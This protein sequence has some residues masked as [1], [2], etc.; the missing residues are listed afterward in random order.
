MA[1][2]RGENT[3][4]KM[5]GLPHCR[6]SVVPPRVKLSHVTQNNEFHSYLFESTGYG[7]AVKRRLNT[8]LYSFLSQQKM[9]KNKDG[10]VTI[11]EF[12]E[13]CQKVSKN[14]YPFC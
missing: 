8:M 5:I 4:P 1:L 14:N 7:E 9:D 10:V 13:S 2:H 11:D 6:N 3:Q 12:I